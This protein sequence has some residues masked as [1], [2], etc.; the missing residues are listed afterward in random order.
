M[1]C[2]HGNHVDGCDLCDALNVLYREIADNEKAYEL[3][4]TQHAR[5]CKQVEALQLR[6]AELESLTERKGWKFVPIEPTGEMLSAGAY[7]AGKRNYEDSEVRN[8]YQDM[9]AASQ[10]ADAGKGGE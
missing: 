6:V 3:L 4:F 8:I 9:I 10:S 2:E 1:S 7:L 5:E